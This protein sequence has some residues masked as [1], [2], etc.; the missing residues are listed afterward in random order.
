MSYAVMKER[1][2]YTDYKISRIKYSQE[3]RLGIGYIL[4][5]AKGETFGIIYGY[6]DHYRSYHREK[7]WLYFFRKPKSLYYDKHTEVSYVKSS[8][9]YD[10][11]E[12]FQVN[13]VL[14]LSHYRIIDTGNKALRGKEIKRND[15][16]YHY[17]LEWN[18]MN[19]GIPYMDLWDYSIHVYYP[20][21]DVSCKTIIYHN[22]SVYTRNKRTNIVSCFIGMHDLSLYST[23]PTF[24]YVSSKLDAIKEYIENFNLDSE[25]QN[26]I[27]GHCGYF[28]CYPGRDDSFFMIDYW[29]SSSADSYMNQLVK[30]HEEKDYYNCCGRDEDDYDSIDLDET[31]KMREEVK[32]K[33]NK[34][35]HYMFLLNE[36][37][38]ELKKQRQQY[39]L[40]LEDIKSFVE[41][42]DEE[43]FQHNYNENDFQKAILQYNSKN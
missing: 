6:R 27:A 20:I 3:S 41:K 13:N 32:K 30:L 29:R 26:F 21:I 37:F 18:L 14:P 33:Y 28:H 22:Y 11:P 25:T 35:A 42:G 1:I 8:S 4:Q 23:E 38:T 12:T 5:C 36:F 39:L 15:G 43:L 9:G 7:T 24:E 34:D 40:Y 17:D 19:E 2:E 31:E 10:K 16:I